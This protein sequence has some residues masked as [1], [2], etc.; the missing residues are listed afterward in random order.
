M[1]EQPWYYDSAQVQVPQMAPAQPQGPMLSAQQA[2]NLRK[3]LKSTERTFTQKV[4]AHVM[5][6]DLYEAQLSAQL[7]L[8]DYEEA[9]RAEALFATM[10]QKAGN[11]TMLYLGVGVAVAAVAGVAVGWHLSRRRTERRFGR[12]D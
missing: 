11:N 3:S 9:A 12:R 8:M 7:A 5:N 1:D 6:A 10:E 2:A 4:G